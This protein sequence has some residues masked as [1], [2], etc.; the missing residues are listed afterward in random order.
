MLADYLV[1]ITGH[2]SLACNYL[3]CSLKIGLKNVLSCLK[4]LMLLPCSAGSGC[5]VSLKPMPIINL[6]CLDR[7]LCRYMG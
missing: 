7:R 4:S 2:V 5:L 6:R 3:G 1:M